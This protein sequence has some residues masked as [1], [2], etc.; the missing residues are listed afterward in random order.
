MSNFSV[1]QVHQLYVVN[2]GLYNSESNVNGEFIK[3][4]KTQEN[5]LYFLIKGADGVL[6]TD[7]IPL[8][9]MKG[10][11]IDAA[12]NG[13]PMRKISVSLDSSINSG[14]PVSGQDYV[15]GI[16]FRNF[17]SSGDGNQYFKDA[18]VH[19]TFAM[20]TAQALFTA[21][22]AS[23]NK[24]FAREPGATASS[25]PYLAFSVSGT[26]SSAKLIIEEKEQEWQLG[27]M[28]SRRLT[29]DV[30]PSTIYTGGEDVIWAAKNTTTGQYYTEEAS[31]TTVGNGKKVA[32]LE[33]FCMG[34]R[35][36]Q[37]R[38]VGWPHV[39]TTK[40]LADPNKE[41]HLIEIHFAF[42]DTGVNSYRTEKEMTIAVP[43]GA[44][45]ANYTAV[46]AIIGAINTAAGSTVI[47][48]LS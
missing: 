32:D 41:Y 11:A 9:T 36:D 6:K 23:L 31:S 30:V 35:G 7:N 2:N 46:N 1:H 43:K 38:N 12:K 47:A 24:A 44:S 29:F 15:L 21:M 37:Y 14:A 34:E 48:T 8:A 42:T 40:Y 39:I 26:G 25:N 19:A 3:A 28:K 10:I 33:W 17:F 22:V 16:N 27:T 4:Q 18:A 45:T 5:E 13:T 20:T